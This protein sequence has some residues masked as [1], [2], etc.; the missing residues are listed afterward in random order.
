MI[1]HNQH[2]LFEQ[3]RTAQT[4]MARNSQVAD[5]GQ[6]IPGTQKPI[7]T[8]FVISKTDAEADV[9][10]CSVSQLRSAVNCLRL[11]SVGKAPKSCIHLLSDHEAS[12]DAYA[13]FTDRTSADRHL[14][15]LRLIA[16][17]E[18]RL[19]LMTLEE[20]EEFAGTP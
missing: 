4:N 12:D 8:F 1:K 9:Y 10:E 20:L 18:Q 7:E 16:K 5:P 2:L 19:H 17:S 3:I 11:Q 15:R 14:A 13:F 6:V